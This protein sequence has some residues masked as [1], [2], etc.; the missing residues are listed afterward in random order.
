[1]VTGWTGVRFDVSTRLPT[2]VMRFPSASSFAEFVGG[3]AS[4]R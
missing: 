3:G 2:A 1:M 4:F